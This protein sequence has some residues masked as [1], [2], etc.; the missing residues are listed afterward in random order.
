MKLPCGSVPTISEGVVLSEFLER[1]GNSTQQASVVFAEQAEFKHDALRFYDEICACEPILR[2][3]TKPPSF[4]DM[5]DLVPLQA[6]D[7]IAYELYKEYERL[8][9]ATLSTEKWFFY[10]AP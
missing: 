2:K 3:R 5:R 8:S 10:R 6:A 9:C 7:L 1:H 4:A